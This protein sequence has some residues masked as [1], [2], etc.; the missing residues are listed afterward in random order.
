MA[1]LGLLRDRK[2]KPKPKH[3][4]APKPKPKHKPANKVVSKKPVAKHVSK[5]VILKAP[6]APIIEKMADEKA[7]EI[8]KDARIPVAPY[9][10]V[11]KENDLPPVLKK[12]KFPVV[13]KVSGQ[14]IIHKTEVGGIIKNIIN[15]T[16]ALVAF[17]KLMAIKGAEKVLIQKQ[18]DGIELIVGAKS[19]P[20]FGAVVS[21]GIGGIYVEILRDVTFRVMPI[22]AADAEAM[23]RELKGFD[24]LAG[25]RGAKPIAL[26]KLTEVIVNL[27]KLVAAQKYKELDINPLFCTSEG[28]WAADVRIIK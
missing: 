9:A 26:A 21:V 6:P 1:L 7:Y 2:S 27:G 23:V 18:L 4:P 3:K 19:D 14:K 17:K 5:P 28:C 20:Q 25:A 24:I 12:L 8:I 10:F 22:S 16:D 11:K 15:D 13:M